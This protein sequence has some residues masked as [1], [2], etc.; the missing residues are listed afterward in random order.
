MRT[1]AREIVKTSVA[2]EDGLRVTLTESAKLEIMDNS[3]HFSDVDSGS[4]S[5]DAIQ[6]VASRE[7]FQGT[8]DSMFSPAGSMT[9]GMLMTVLARLSGQDTTGGETWYSAGMEW[10][11]KAGISDGT[12]PEANVTREQLA[13][14]LYR[15]AGAEGRE[16]VALTSFPDNSTVSSWA[17][18]AMGWAVQNGIITGTG[19]GTL[20]PAGNASRAEV[21]VMLQRFIS[22]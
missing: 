3:K 17:Q 20:N 10:A 8:S 16:A 2:T 5:A 12:A 4:W 15:F 7:L 9:R 11:K 19:S 6:F 1:A 22:L 14:M 18:D 13:V 21:A